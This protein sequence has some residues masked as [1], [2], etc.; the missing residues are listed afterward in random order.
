MGRAAAS[1]GRPLAG[2]SQ[3]EG[4]RSTGF[5]FFFALFVSLNHRP[6]GFGRGCVGEFPRS[7]PAGDGNTALGTSALPRGAKSDSLS[8][9]FIFIFLGGEKP[10]NPLRLE[11]ER[12]LRYFA[13]DASDVDILERLS[14]FLSSAGKKF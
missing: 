7:Q 10:K 14:T 8:R 4:G 3:R 12:T 9:A 1:R 5:G 2:Q 13:I 6:G 11:A